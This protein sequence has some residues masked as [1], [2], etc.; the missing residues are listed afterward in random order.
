MATDNARP[1]KG[2]RDGISQGEKNIK[3]QLRELFTKYLDAT[4]KD[5]TNKVKERKMKEFEDMMKD[6]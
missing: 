5:P 4:I 2:Y 3:A 1:R 6:D